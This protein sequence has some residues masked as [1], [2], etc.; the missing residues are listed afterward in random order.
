LRILV[1]AATQYQWRKILC[2]PS[3]LLRAACVN[4]GFPGPH[5]L[6]KVFS[7]LL[8]SPQSPCTLLQLTPPQHTH[9][10]THPWSF[11]QQA[12]SIPSHTAPSVS[13][14]MLH[15]LLKTV[16]EV[17]STSNCVWSQLYLNLCIWYIVS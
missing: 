13:P 8:L 10:P 5:Q 15:P 6:S 16:F 2:A 17:K 3:N 9:T 1:Q 14:V 12:G 4:P 11:Q 7:K